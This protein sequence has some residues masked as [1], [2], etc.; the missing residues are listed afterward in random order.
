MN[1]RM[2][3]YTER[4]FSLYRNKVFTAC[5]M[6]LANYYIPHAL[7]DSAYYDSFL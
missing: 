3:I 2:G 1:I 5:N 6:S 4:I 7:C